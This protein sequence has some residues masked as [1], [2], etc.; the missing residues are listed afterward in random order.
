MFQNCKNDK[1]FIIATFMDPRFKT[2]EIESHEKYE[3]TNHNKLD[4]NTEMAQTN[5]Q[6]LWI[7]TNSF[8]K[9]LQKQSMSTTVNNESPISLIKK[10]GRMIFIFNSKIHGFL[11]ILY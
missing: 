4:N 9:I 10:E 1:A 2:F 8:L 7:Q 3:V 11:V 5:S 6:V